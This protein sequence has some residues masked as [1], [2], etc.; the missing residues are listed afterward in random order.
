MA[1]LLFGTDV[2]P[3]LTSLLG[4]SW[5]STESLWESIGAPE[6]WENTDGASGPILDLGLPCCESGRIEE[7]RFIHDPLEDIES[8]LFSAIG[9]AVRS[10]CLINDCLRLAVFEGV[11]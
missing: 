1:G 10:L 7:R 6:P 8:L 3:R 9:R 11:G 4:G 2:V 5:E